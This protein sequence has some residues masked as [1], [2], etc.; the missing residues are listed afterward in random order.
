MAK[1]KQLNHLLI[2]VVLLSLLSFNICAFLLPNANAASITDNSTMLE[3]LN[4]LPKVDTTRSAIAEK[5]LSI[6]SNVVG[7]DTGKYSINSGEYAEDTYIGVVP[8]ENVRYTLEANGSKLDMLYTFANGNLRMIH[9]LESEGSP[10]LT[11]TATRSGQVLGNKTLQVVDVQ[12]TAENFLNSYQSQSGKQF[13]G[14]LVTMLKDIDA[15][16][17]AT[18]IVDNVKLEVNS[19][20]HDSITFRWLYTSNGIDAP[21]KCVALSYKNGFLKYFIDNWD[22]Y[23]IGSTDINLSEEEAIGLAMNSARAFS[24]KIGSDN[25][26]VSVKNFTVSN[27]MIWETIFYSNLYADNLR[28]EDPLMLYP[29]RHV[30]VSLDKFYPGNVYGIE[31]YIWADTKSVCQVKERFS[32]LDPPANLVATAEDYTIE[33]LTNQ[34]STGSVNLNS[35]TPMWIALPAF[36]TLM[37]GIIPVILVKR[38]N[39]PKH[40]FK[41]GGIVLC[42]LIASTIL[43]IP[44]SAVNAE[45][46]RRTLIWGSEST[47]DTSYYGSTGRKTADEIY[48]QQVTS[49]ALSNYFNDDGYDTDN[50]QGSGSIAAQIVNN[51][52]DSETNYAQVAVVD[53]DHGVGNPFNFPGGVQNEFHYMFEDNIGTRVNGQ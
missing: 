48:R 13:Y 14:K 4:A 49:N 41:T 27:A 28:N 21:S 16:K 51:I 12:A 36:V 47:G 43:L 33:P 45:P 24:W 20:S 9:V 35:M 31:V 50:Y 26:T 34:V 11:K 15:S 5:G 6:L 8:Q 29:M 19:T 30:W 1:T 22:L 18:K 32:T 39:L 38:R 40:S 17:N 7:V 46:I 42:L 53:F 52:S 25:S 37:I 10:L 2:Q 23:K 3:E 44:I